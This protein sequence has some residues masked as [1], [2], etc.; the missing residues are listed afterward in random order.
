MAQLVQKYLTGPQVQAR[1]A[2]TKMTVWRWLAD[3]SLG[4]PRPIKINSRNYWDQVELDRWD[5]ER[6]RRG[7][8][9]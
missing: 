1:Y 3:D 7:D 5:S 2:V 9:A 6:L 4:F 8:A